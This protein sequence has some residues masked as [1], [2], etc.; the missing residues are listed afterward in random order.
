MGLAIDDI[1]GAEAD[2]LCK[3]A[4]SGD[5]RAFERLYALVLP[6]LKSA[7]RS[8][9]K[10]W[11]EAE[12]VQ[13]QL[14]IIFRF[15]VIEKFNEAKGCFGRFTKTVIKRRA[16]TALSRTSKTRKAWFVNGV[17][18]YDVEDEDEHRFIQGVADNKTPSP[19][20]S[21]EAAES[22]RLLLEAL[23]P[24]ERFVM[25]ERLSGTEGYEP[26]ARQVR[27]GVEGLEEY[28]ALTR[29]QMFKAID[30]AQSRIRR[31]AIAIISEASAKRGKR[32]YTI[33]QKN[34]AK[35][36]RNG[37]ATGGAKEVVQSLIFMVA[38]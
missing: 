17:V 12:D 23:S 26:V 19:G 4:R 15:E 25:E 11:L 7:S 6:I 13:Q 9:A 28:K 3:L 16:F 14:A 38:K 8:V 1:D 20:A 31:K 18:S 33:E 27:R 22:L 5:E 2:R 36:Q 35:S 30:N 32:R 10:R 21:L 37:V 34:P 24:F 29:S